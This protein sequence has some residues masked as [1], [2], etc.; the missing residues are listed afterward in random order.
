[1]K[2][3]TTPDFW[4][5]YAI[6]PDEIKEQARKAYQLWQENPSHPSLH[7]KKVGK[8]LWSARITRDFRAL[9]LKKDDDYYWFWIG[10]HDEYLS[11]LK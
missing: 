8:N 5:S 9:A 7:F 10:T 6:L 1:M 3:L 11:V 4:Q 2:S